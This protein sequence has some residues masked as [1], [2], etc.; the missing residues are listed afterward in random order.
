MI[1]GSQVMNMVMR[2][3][4]RKGINSAIDVG[5]K[6]FNKSDAP[7]NAGEAPPANQ[8]TDEQRS[9]RERI[10]AERRARRAAREN[11]QD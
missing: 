2:L 5:M 8:L 9:E 10:R 3:I 11:A 4:M 1:N 6:Q 7:P